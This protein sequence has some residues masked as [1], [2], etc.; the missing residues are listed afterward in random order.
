MAEFNRA[1]VRSHMCRGPFRLINDLPAA[2]NKVI[3]GTQ[4]AVKT[5]MTMAS[6]HQQKLPEPAAS[7]FFSGG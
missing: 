4:Q 7:S 1:K 6:V 5:P 2:N 3:T